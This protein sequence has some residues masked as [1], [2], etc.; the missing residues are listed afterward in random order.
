MIVSTGASTL[1][2]IKHIHTLLTSLEA[3][4]AFL[5]AVASY[6]TSIDQLNL[7]RINTLQT[8]FT[9]THIGFSGHDEGI[10][11]SLFAA[12]MGARVIEKHFTLDKTLKGTDQGFSL[13]PTEMK[14]LMEKLAALDKMMGNS[15]EDSISINSFELDARKKMGKGIYAATDIKTGTV[16]TL[17]HFSFKSPGTTLTP[18]DAKNMVGKKIITDLKQDQPFNLQ[19]IMNVL[20]T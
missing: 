20:K 16:L 13:C 8:L 2:E 3:E 18:S 7:T 5:Y 17:D 15:Y 1:A 6:P 11:G 9:D 12:A 14:M 10:E 4:F 19:M